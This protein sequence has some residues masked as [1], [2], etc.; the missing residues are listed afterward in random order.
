METPGF[1]VLKVDK[2]DSI[3]LTLDGEWLGSVWAKTVNPEI[4]CF[5]Y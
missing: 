5:K 3:H 2:T 1:E 4:F